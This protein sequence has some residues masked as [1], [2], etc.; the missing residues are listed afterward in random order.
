MAS[1]AVPIT[2]DWVRA[3]PKSPAVVPLSKANSLPKAMAVSRLTT[4]KKKAI[5]R[6]SAPCFLREEKNWG[7]SWNLIYLS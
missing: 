4:P 1:W 7:A 3:P 6:Y 2:V 5:R